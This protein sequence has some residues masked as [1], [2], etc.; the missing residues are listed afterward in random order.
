MWWGGLKG[1]LAIAVVLSIPDSLPEKQFLFD[2][3]IGVVLFTL[4]VSA[5]TIRPLME[6]LGLDKLTEGEDLE[7]RNSLITARKKSA[8]WLSELR[9]YSL[10]PKKTTAHLLTRIRLAFG[11]GLY[12]EGS[13]VHMQGGLEIEGDA[14][15]HTMLTDEAVAIMQEYVDTDYADRI[16]WL[17]R[18][19]GL[20]HPR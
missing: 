17:E 14:F 6:R 5:P 2:L 15:I 20:L 3:T 10:L 16:A 11:I 1:G 12:D 8:S 19:K 18:K 4:L 13:E 7:L 9:G